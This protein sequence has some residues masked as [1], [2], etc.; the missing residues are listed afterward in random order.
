MDIENIAGLLM[1][2]FA[3]VHTASDGLSFSIEMA[4]NDGLFVWALAI[5]P[6]GLLYCLVLFLSLFA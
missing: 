2:N 3:A 1:D 4:I 6:I 5:S